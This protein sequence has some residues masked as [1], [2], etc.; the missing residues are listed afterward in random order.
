MRNRR[1]ELKLDIVG[2]DKDNICYILIKEFM[3]GDKSE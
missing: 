2:I 1:L 3:Q